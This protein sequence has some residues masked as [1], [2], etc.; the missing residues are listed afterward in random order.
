[1][2]RKRLFSLVLV[3][4]MALLVSAGVTAAVA[5]PEPVSGTFTYTSST[6]N[7][8]RFAGGNMI[9]DVS[10]TVDYTGNL[11]G[12]LTLHGTL[13]L[14]ADGSAN[15]HSTQVFTGTVNGVAGTLTFNFAGGGPAG[16]FRGTQTI[17]GGTGGL[18]DL[19]GT[20]YDVGIVVLPDGPR[21]TY[22]GQLQ[23][24]P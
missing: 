17:T 14:H 21:G 22:T 4:V 15:A 1:M 8:V 18:A 10:A 24:A 11:E 19:H 23:T 7:S 6:F 9:V 2:S 5:S 16:L 3:T 12:T 20:L 13:I